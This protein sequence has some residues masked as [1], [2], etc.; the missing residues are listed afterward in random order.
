MKIL[1]LFKIEL[2]WPAILLHIFNSESRKVAFGWWVFIL[3]SIFN[4][5]GEVGE[6]TW[7]ICTVISAVLIG[8]GTVTDELI[9]VGR[10]WIEA[11]FGG[12]P[13][14]APAQAPASPTPAP[15]PAP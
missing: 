4:Y 7:L 13:E 1:D 5:I 3:A 12:K 6:S 15:E 9:K 8:G 2:G 10:A 11:K 14:P